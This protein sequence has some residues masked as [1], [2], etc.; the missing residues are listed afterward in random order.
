ML[1]KSRLMLG[2]CHYPS[3]ETTTTE[4]L[5]FPRGLVTGGSGRK[6]LSLK[7]S[8]NYLRRLRCSDAVCSANILPPIAKEKNVSLIALGASGKSSA[9]RE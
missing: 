5:R 6:I 1:I 8:R 3:T 4:P 7:G 9:Q 2:E